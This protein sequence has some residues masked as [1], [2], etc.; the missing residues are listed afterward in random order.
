MPIIE[1]IIEASLNFLIGKALNVSFSKIL[2]FINNKREVVRYLRLYLMK[3]VKNIAL[4][5]HSRKSIKL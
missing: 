3:L 2:N 1:F 4:V 5:M